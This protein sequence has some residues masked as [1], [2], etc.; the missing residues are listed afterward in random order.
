MRAN[1]LNYLIPVSKFI[2]KISRPEMRITTQEYSKVKELI[3]NGDC[4]LSRT[5]WELSNFFLPGFWKH[6]GIY[7]DGYVYEATTHGVRK[8]LLSEFCFKKDVV[9]I[10]RPNFDL[11]LNYAEMY[12]DRTLGLG[13]DWAFSWMDNTSD[14]WYCSE[15]VYAFYHR[16]NEIFLFMFTPRPTLGELTIKPTD[17]WDAESKFTRIFSSDKRVM[18][19]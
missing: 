7:L 4:L 15:Y 3:K 13:Y 6:C 9:G 17:Y 12:L 2:A 1:L 11:E 5:D 10:A 14:A 19:R 18:L 8:V 16:M